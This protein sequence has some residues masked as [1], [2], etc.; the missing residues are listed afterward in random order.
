MLL[1]TLIIVALFVASCAFAGE[2]PEEPVLLSV[3]LATGFVLSAPLQVEDLER[4]SLAEIAGSD[5]IPQA[6]FGFSNSKWQAFKLLV[7]P[8]DVIVRARS[9]P[10]S[11]RSLAGWRGLLLVRDGVVIGIFTEAVS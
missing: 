6:P 4:A 7:Q 11:W 2:G 3:F 10:E 9:S 1:R 8:G 5:R